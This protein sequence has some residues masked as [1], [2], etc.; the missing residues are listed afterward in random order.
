MC[1][2]LFLTLTPADTPWFEPESSTGDSSSAEMRPK[3][4]EC[5]LLPGPSTDT[6]R[7][8]QLLNALAKLHNCF[9]LRLPNM[10]SFMSRQTRSRR[11]FFHDPRCLYLR[12]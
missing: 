10:L 1:W 3:R 12:P 6:S 5:P 2:V 4:R 8:V 7:S 11:S 9:L